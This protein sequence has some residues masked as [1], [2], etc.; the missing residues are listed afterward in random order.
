MGTKLLPA[1]HIKNMI[2]KL[3]RSGA[4]ADDKADAWQKRVKK[5]E[6]FNELRR[7]AEGGDTEAMFEL[8]NAYGGVPYTG[9]AGEG[10]LGLAKDPSAALHWNQRGAEGGHS[11]CMLLLMDHYR[12]DDRNPT[13]YMYW[14][15]VMAERPAKTKESLCAMAMLGCLFAPDDTLSGGMKTLGDNVEIYDGRTLDVRRAS[16][17][18]SYFRRAIV[19]ANEMVG[20][21]IELPEE[22]QEF[23]LVPEIE[24]WLRNHATDRNAASGSGSTA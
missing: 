22:L 16:M 13:M 23:G 10:N 7:K 11:G 15:T 6:I 14:M 19:R 18:T 12:W 8:A 5:Q 21:G 4:V 9:G 2:E 1:H 24:A 3:V 20:D 17:A